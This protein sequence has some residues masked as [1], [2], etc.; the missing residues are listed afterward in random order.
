MCPTQINNLPTLG[1]ALQLINQIAL[2]VVGNEVAAKVG[3]TKITQSSVSV[4]ASAALNKILKE[5][6]NHA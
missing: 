5:K 1:V 4:L 2:T 6:S 3:E